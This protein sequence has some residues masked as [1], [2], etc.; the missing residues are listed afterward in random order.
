[1]EGIL[2]KI[3]GNSEHS[4]ETQNICN[5]AW[6]MSPGLSFFPGHALYNVLSINELFHTT[7]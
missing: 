1:M 4:L 2:I 7:D 5:E 3:L 6:Q